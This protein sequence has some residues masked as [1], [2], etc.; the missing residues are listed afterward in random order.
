MLRRTETFYWKKQLENH[1]TEEKIFTLYEYEGVPVGSG[2]AVV[3]VL[4]SNTFTSFTFASPSFFFSLGS[5]V[6]TVVGLFSTS[7]RN[8]QCDL[9][10]ATRVVGSYS[11]LVFTGRYN[12]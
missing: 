6:E 12:C 9:L 1:T 8:A 11:R 5:L 4:P 3:V 2:L 7:L 10:F